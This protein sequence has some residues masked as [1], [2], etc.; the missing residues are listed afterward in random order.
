MFGIPMQ[1][2][3]MCQKFAKRPILEMLPN[4]T[5]VTVGTDYNTIDFSQIIDTDKYLFIIVQVYY[6]GIM[7]YMYIQTSFSTGTYTKMYTDRKLSLLSNSASNYK[8]FGLRY[9][10]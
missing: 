2:S 5:T 3:T 7:H 6:L 8:L 1:Y 9:E 4:P 10:D